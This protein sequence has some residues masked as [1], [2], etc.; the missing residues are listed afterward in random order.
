LANRSGRAYWCKFTKKGQS[1][2]AGGVHAHGAVFKISRAGTLTTLYSFC[3]LS[4]CADGTAPY[5][6]LILGTDGSFYGTTESGG[7]HR[8]NGTI[9][10]MTPAGTL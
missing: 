4:N 2:D 3:A 9:F 7:A 10:K 1:H 5:A 6:G 8:N